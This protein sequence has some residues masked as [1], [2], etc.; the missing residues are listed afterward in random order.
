MNKIEMIGVIM[1]IFSIV[2]VLIIK[3]K[4]PFFH[5]CKKPFSDKKVFEYKYTIIDKYIEIIVDEN[6]K[7]TTMHTVKLLDDKNNYTYVNLNEGDYESAKIK[8]R[9]KFVQSKYYNEDGVCV[10][11]NTVTLF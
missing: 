1:I 7:Q 11:K 9:L 8:G 3:K 5:I 10:K 6:N 2:I 4:L